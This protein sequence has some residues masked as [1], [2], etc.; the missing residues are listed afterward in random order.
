MAEIKKLRLKSAAAR[1]SFHQASL[2]L[3]IAKVSV[4][5]G[6]FHLDQLFDYQVPSE[7]DEVAKIGSAV[8][9]PFGSRSLSGVI[10]DRTTEAES[11]GL[12]FIEK[13]SSLLPL[14]SVGDLPFFRAVA[15]RY[16]L[17]LHD[18]LKL[19]VPE[20]APKS[21]QL[22]QQS[23]IDTPSSHSQSTP[24]S[25]SSHT[26]SSKNRDRVLHLMAPGDTPQSAITKLI[27][28]L[29]PKTQVLIVVPDE[30]DISALQTGLSGYEGDGLV[31]MS[32]MLPRS[33]RY[34]NYLRTLTAHPRII[35][36]TRSA[37]FTH[38]LP[39]SVLI[40]YGDGEPS[41]YSQQ[42]PY[43]NAREIAL[44][45]AADQDLHFF[46]YAPTLELARLV[47]N[48]WLRVE[49][50][51]INVTGLTFQDSSNSHLTTISKALKMGSVLVVSSQPGYINSF[52]CQ[53]CRNR[54]L[55]DC[56]GRLTLDKRELALCSLCNKEFGNWRCSFC[57]ERQVRTISKGGERL[58]AE[59]GKAY[60]GTSIL[61]SSAR[62]RIDYLPE[63]NHL[64]IST[65][66]C[67]PVGQY[68]GVVL[69]DGDYLFNRVGLH[70]DE[71]ARRSWF[72][73]LSMKSKAG[74]GYISLP[75]DHPVSQSLLKWSVYPQIGLELEEHK[76]AILPPF[77]R[78]AVISGDRSE[79]ERL[80]EV[81]SQ[82][83]LFTIVSL[84]EIDIRRSKL[85]LRAPMEK[86]EEFSLFFYDFK[87]V[88]SLGKA[89]LLDIALDPYEI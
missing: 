37:V 49:H 42:F 78:L 75:S 31:I 35:I 10:L 6:I 80:R 55:C 85:V 34:R 14:I 51:P 57:G 8:L 16:A 87:R 12:K 81:L 1:V 33:D 60:P 17:T 53:K 64:V 86:S 39:G 59:L 73:A 66:G 4:D 19:V 68:S 5:T 9:V 13:V 7:L 76:A 24:S 3:P 63:G 41:L 20:R 72:L 67:E 45:R 70:R 21:E 84:L 65:Y 83:E 88:R 89:Q 11:A 23:P 32:S 56:G 50:K 44:L 18:V 15:K 82:V 27:A 69:L 77:Y 2:N 40:V 71:E 25:P 29:A 61:M 28:D 22:F 38:L 26:N 52:S 58:G 46:S 54:A 48:G 36:G 62:H 47:E 74:I 79:I 43:W 30:K